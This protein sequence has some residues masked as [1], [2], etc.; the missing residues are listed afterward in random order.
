M[1]ALIYCN[2]FILARLP[3]YIAI[4]MV[5]IISRLLRLIRLQ[6]KVDQIAWISGQDFMQP[7][8]I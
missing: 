7:K 8:K 4:F 2:L 3:V 6:A 5:I 1:D